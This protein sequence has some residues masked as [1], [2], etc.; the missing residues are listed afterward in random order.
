MWLKN[1]R[2]KMSR[3]L[4]SSEEIADKGVLYPDDEDYDTVKTGLMAV[5]QEPCHKCDAIIVARAR[6]GLQPRYRKHIREE[7][8]EET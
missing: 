1:W 5:A 3:T 8:E 2:E 6:I 4:V 7:H